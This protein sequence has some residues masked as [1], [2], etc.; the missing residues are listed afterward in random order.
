V[1]FRRFRSLGP[2]PWPLTRAEVESFAAHDLT[3]ARL[4]TTAVPGKPE[5]LRWRAEFQR[6]R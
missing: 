6:P 5:D 2:P 3:V 1:R 4:K